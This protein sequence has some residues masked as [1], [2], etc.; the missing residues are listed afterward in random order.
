MEKKKH[1]RTGLIVLCILLAGSI[2]GLFWFNH[3]YLVMDGEVYPRATAE[4]D[5]SGNPDPDLD[6]LT[7][8]T[9]LQVLNLRDT[10]ITVEEYET[11]RAAMPEC[12]ILWS[13]PFQGSYLPDD[14]TEITVSSLSSEDVALLTAYLPGLT[15]VNAGSCRDYDQLVALQAAFPQ[16]NISYSIRVN[17]RDWPVDTAGMALTDAD[18]D[19]LSQMLPYLP[20]VTEISL[21]GKLPLAEDLQALTAAYSHIRFYWQIELFGMIADVDTTELDLSGI[22]METVDE[23]EAAVAYLP[24]LERVYMHNCGISNEE[25]DAL[26]HRHEGVR[27]V[28]TVKIGKMSVST[29]ATTFMPGKINYFIN[30]SLSYNLRYCIDMVCLDLGH[31]YISNCDFVAFMP[32]LKYLIL[33]DTDIWDLT[34]LENCKELIYLEVFLTPVKDFSPLLGCTALE[35]LNIC[36]TD[37]DIDVICQMTWLNNLWWSPYDAERYEILHAHLPDTHLELN[38]KSSTGNGWRNLQNYYDH[39]DLLG[40]YYMT[41]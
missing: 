40:M 3:T 36:F 38:A 18:A 6:K 29:D 11:L 22:P 15:D 1:L 7:E 34:P 30:D 23:V 9:A 35:D 31:Q 2:G 39:R 27:F 5:L 41:S 12:R 21:D 25:M 20:E 32:K 28:W 16:A 19:E 26:N 33:A 17:G 13:V 24:S 10:G 14:T 8:L 37:A 4:L